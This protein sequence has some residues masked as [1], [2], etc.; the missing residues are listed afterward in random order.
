[1]IHP[2]KRILTVNDYPSPPSFSSEFYSAFYQ[3]FNALNEIGVTYLYYTYVNGGY[4]KSISNYEEWMDIYRS[5]DLIK[6]CTLK[7]LAENH[8]PMVIPWGDI[9]YL[10]LD[11]RK[12]MQARNSYHM[13]NGLTISRKRDEGTEVIVLATDSPAH[14][15]ARYIIRDKS[16]IVQTVLRDFSQRA[17]ADFK[18]A[19]KEL[20]FQKLLSGASKLVPH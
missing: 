8:A 7:R 12:V 20:M 15:L 18:S 5:E 3:Q 16:E 14:D 10:N 17:E 6:H 1:M 4:R 9:T 13:L 11:E 2:C 19:Q